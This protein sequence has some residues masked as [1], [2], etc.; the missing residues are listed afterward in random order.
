MLA[1]WTD[2]Q[3]LHIMGSEKSFLVDVSHDRQSR[4]DW[5]SDPQY[6][7]VSC[8]IAMVAKMNVSNTSFTENRIKGSWQKNAKNVLACLLFYLSTSSVR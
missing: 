4:R 3:C 6:F 1:A 7:D 5:G 8:Y 2:G